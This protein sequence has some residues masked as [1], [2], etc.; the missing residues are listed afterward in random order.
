M[1]GCLPSEGLLARTGC[2]LHRTA[3][4]LP[5]LS[6]PQACPAQDIER[7]HEELGTHVLAY[8]NGKLKYAALPGKGAHACC[9]ARQGQ[10]RAAARHLLACVGLSRL[11]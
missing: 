3:R 7:T 6:C 5:R 9:A 2:R 10:S 4:T 11:A 1:R 8:E